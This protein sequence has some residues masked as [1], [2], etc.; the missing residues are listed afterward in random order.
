MIDNGLLI[1][2]N[3]IPFPQAQ[4]FIRQPTL[5]EILL[6]TE[7]RFFSSCDIITFS[8]DKLS[9][10]D[11]TLLSD[12]SNFEILMS[13]INDE[14][15]NSEGI[16]DDC[17]NLL[18]LL[19]LDYDISFQD[20]FILLQKEKELPHTIN[21][22]NFED[23]KEIIKDIFCMNKKSKEEG[24]YNPSG[25]MAEKLAN[26][27][28]KAREKV[29]A[30]KGQ[31][32]KGTVLDRYISILSIGLKLDMN[33]IL[34]YTMYQLY[35]SLDRFNLKEEYELSMKARLAGASSES[36]DKVEHWMKDTHS[37]L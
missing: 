14:S 34:N 29:A 15:V 21:I 25:P 5:K 17:L 13:I 11:K 23:F 32:L 3:D 30:A 31:N 37:E 19:F 2:G 35:E 36:L 20:N 9:D 7:K 1:S 12:K 8:K 24:E 4:M 27:F 22:E 16:K 6:L 28:K 18:S 10:K 26:R 33:V